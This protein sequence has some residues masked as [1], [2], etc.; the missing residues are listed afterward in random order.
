MEKDRNHWDYSRFVEEASVWVE[1]TCSPEEGDDT[2]K[3]R[4]LKELSNYGALTQ[5]EATAA[6]VVECLQ[7]TRAGL[8]WRGVYCLRHSVLESLS[9]R[10]L[11]R[12][13][14]SKAIEKAKKPE[15]VYE[16]LAEYHHDMVKTLQW[17]GYGNVTIKVAIDEW[18]RLELKRLTELVNG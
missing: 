2:L 12:R 13:K 1:H 5:D 3:K 6:D 7:A 17:A 16:S 15:E 4:A 10:N 14:H 11:A 18:N 9:P 8:D